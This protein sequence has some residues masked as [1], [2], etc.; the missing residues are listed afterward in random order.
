MVLTLDPW[1]VDSGLLTPT[2]KVK[3]PQVLEAYATQVKALY[4][5]APGR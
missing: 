5:P 1:T 2:L 4:Q 3:R